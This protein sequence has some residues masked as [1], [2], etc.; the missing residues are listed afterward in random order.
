MSATR[1]TSLAMLGA[2][3]LAGGGRA[4]E[5][6]RISLG[7]ATPGGGFPIYGEAFAAAVNKADPTLEIIPRN[8]RG[9][10]ENLPLLER[11]E[12]DLGLVQGEAAHEALAGIGRAPADLRII[13]AMYSSAGF[14]GVK[15]DSPA[16]TI[17]DLVGKPIAFGAAGS[18]LVILARYVLDGLGLDM[19]RD[20]QAILLERAGDGPAMV[21]DG[22]AAAL[23]GGGIGW[24]GFVAVGGL[25]GR[26]IAPDAE[27][28][29]RIRAKHTFLRELTIPQGS[30]P[31]LNQALQSVGSWSF[32]LCRRDLPENVGYRV[33]K[34]LRS[35][36]TD[37]A[38]RLPQAA[39][40][41]LENTVVAAP[42][43]ALLQAG[44]VRL[45]REAAL[46][47]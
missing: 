45:A 24:P 25:P 46:M 15:A 27:G 12:L 7:T 36:E 9:S 22:R 21:A 6:S 4:Q 39:E 20:F 33:A 13:S 31:G 34:A 5:R 16:R 8:T 28:I 23:W 44:V 1:R 17:Q 2:T 37:L 26:F 19:N 38:R 43:P 14:F 32:V 40:T 3:I 29:K 11:G 42:Q 18:G 30:Y 35:A 10:A 47:K 41:S